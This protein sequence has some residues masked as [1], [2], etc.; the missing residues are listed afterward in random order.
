MQI[1][2]AEGYTHLNLQ[3]FK[4]SELSLVTEYA[5]TAVDMHPD[6]KLKNVRTL[7]MSQ[8]QKSDSIFLHTFEEVDFFEFAD[9][10]TFSAPRK[11][12]QAVFEIEVKVG[13][14]HQKYLRRTMKFY[15]ALALIGGY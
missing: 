2:Q 7:S 5:Q 3:Q 8:L 6:F 10:K 1:Y 9:F 13:Q 4:E 12:G 15:E 11:A 14:K